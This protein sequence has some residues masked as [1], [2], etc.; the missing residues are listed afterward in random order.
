[1]RGNGHWHQME[2]RSWWNG[3]VTAL[4]GYRA[5]R[6]SYETGGLLTGVTCPACKRLKKDSKKGGKK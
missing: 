3:E 5:P 4:C 2:K 6:G 1:M